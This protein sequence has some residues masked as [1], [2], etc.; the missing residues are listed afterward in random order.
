VDRRPPGASA[1]A[2]STRGAS[3]SRR[4]PASPASRRRGPPR[5]RR[6][7]KRDQ[8]F[9]FDAIA[10]DP[11]SGSVA[12][13]TFVTVTGF[14]TDFVDGAVVTFDGVPPPASPSRTRSA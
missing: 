3:R 12:G 9:T 11:P 5:R 6:R 8:A 13:G 4:R 10:L 2:S 7:L 14:G 1:S